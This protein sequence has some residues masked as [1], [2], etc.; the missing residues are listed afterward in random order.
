MQERP[1]IRQLEYFVALS[2]T[3][4]F[5]KAAE[6]CFVSQPALSAQIQKL[7]ATLGVRLFERDARRVLPTAVGVEIAAKAREVL[8]RCDQLGD[9]A[10]HFGDPLAGRLRLGVIPTVAPYVL[11]K[12]LPGVRTR[13]PKLELLIREDRT[14]NLL[15]ELSA[16]RLDVLLLALDVDLGDVATQ[17]LFEEA[18]VFAAPTTHRLARRKRIAQDELEGERVL[19]L[20]EGHCLRDSALEVCRRGRAREVEEFRATSLGTLVQMVASGV[21]VTL[22]PEMAVS[23]E[24]RAGEIAV[25]PFAP[26]PPVR[27][28]GLAWRPT[29][30]LSAGFR[31]L[32]EYL[33][34]LL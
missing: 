9:V 26:P 23:V 33:E 31:A 30:G 13:F 8:A 4:N 34:T 1:S 6:R 15:Q 28:I 17:L 29:S 16:G 18:F 3:L 10:Q 12:V 11:P 2:E 22:L 27:Q 32:G 5:R 7:E 24:A 25:V 20:E 14:S 19:L 21:G